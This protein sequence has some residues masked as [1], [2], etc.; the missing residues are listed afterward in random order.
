[1]RPRGDGDGLVLADLLLGWLLPPI[2]P[3]VVGWR[4][5]D[6][7]RRSMVEGGIILLADLSK[8]RRRQYYE[9]TALPNTVAPRVC[10]W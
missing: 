4:Q 10:D 5:I 6:R 9:K 2:V 3:V 8:L 1:M 7:G